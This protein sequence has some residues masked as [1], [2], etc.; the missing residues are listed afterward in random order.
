MKLT[1]V[2]TLLCL[3]SFAQ[4]LAMTPSEKIEPLDLYRSANA[5][6]VSGDTRRAIHFY[7]EVVEFYHQQ[8]RANELPESY[9][10]M[11]LSFAL[12]GHYPQSIRYHKKALRAH[13]KYRRNDSADEILFNMGLAYQLAGKDKKSRKYLGG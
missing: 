1:I 2:F 6:L 13:R 11:A 4:D 10:G 8:H 7:K 5:S 3:S 9:L 12:N